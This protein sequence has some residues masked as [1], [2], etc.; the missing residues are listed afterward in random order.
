MQLALRPLRRDDFGLVSRWLAEPHVSRWWDPRH[1]DGFIESKYG[2]RIDGLEPTEVFA[3]EADNRPIGLFQWCP[4]EYYAWWPSELG[5]ADDAV[6][7]DALIGDATKVGRG[8]GTALLEHVLPRLL[9]RFPDAT[10]ILGAPAAANVASWRVLEKGGFELVHEGELV[11]DGRPLSRIYRLACTPA[12]AADISVD[13]FRTE[14]LEAMVTWANPLHVESMAELLERA[15][16]A[17]DVEYLACRCL[18][19][20]PLS[21]VCIDFAE[22]AD[23]GTLTQLSTRQA[24]EGRGLASRLIQEAERRIRARGLTYAVMGVEADDLKAAGMYLRRGYL[25][26]SSEQA[27]WEYE[28]EQ[29]VRRLYETEVQLLRKEVQV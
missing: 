7:I 18:S 5:L 16:I 14:D 19:G 20:E 29:G 8:V 12:A 9:E 2:P 11:R 22:H 28:D 17:G 27:A 1:D 10:D 26:W 24:W 23:A 21:K 15:R 6:V 13:D 4:A 3:V 25:P